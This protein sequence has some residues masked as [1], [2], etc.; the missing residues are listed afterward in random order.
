MNNKTKVYKDND[1]HQ[2]RTINQSFENHLDAIQNFKIDPYNPALLITSIQGS[3]KTTAI[4][5]TFAKSEDAILLVQ[6]NAK[7]DQMIELLKIYPNLNYRVFWGMERICSEYT[8]D[9]KDKEERKEVYSMVSNLRANKFRTETIHSI[10]HKK[11]NS[12]IGDCPYSTQNKELKGRIIETVARFNAQITEG[13]L[14][15]FIHEGRL[16][17]IDEADGLL[18]PVL[19]AIDNLPLDYDRENI[20]KNDVFL[21]EIWDLHTIKGTMDILTTQYKQMV[22]DINFSNYKNKDLKMIREISELIRLIS[23]KIYIKRLKK[24]DINPDFEKYYISEL[25]PIY[26]IFKYTIENKLK[27]ILGSATLRHHRINF[28]TVQNYFELALALQK[29]RCF[30]QL[31]SMQDH[32]VSYARQLKLVEYISNLIQIDGIKE[33]RADFI[34]RQREILIIP[35]SK[36]INKLHGY[37]ISHYLKAK[38]DQEKHDLWRYEIKEEIRFALNLYYVIFCHDP[39]NILLISFKAVNN[40]I[41]KEFKRIKEGGHLSRDPILK[42]IENTADFFS[43]EMHGT[44]ADTGGYDLILTIGDPLDGS[45]SQYAGKMNLI[46]TDKSG[47]IKNPKGFEIKPDADKKDKM[48]ILESMLSE[49]LEAFHRGRW[50][51]PIISIGNFLTSND[52]KEI[53]KNILSD[54]GFKIINGIEAWKQIADK[55]YR[56]KKYYTE[57]PKNIASLPDDL[58]FVD[59]SKW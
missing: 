24:W 57:I 55:N 8:K 26:F 34:P 39:K 46:N 54:D 20:V 45:V 58:K 52:D 19:L 49:L 13:N 47:K 23:Q 33:F 51:L 29:D 56:N 53:I 59:F 6:S 14:Y 3:G 12:D 38:T 11:F 5:E 28:E 7:I 37:S 43:N 27:L 42:R 1:V 21:P 31:K 15:K 9:F 35:S 16:I 48:F 30:K 4:I 32:G 2:A 36:K 44:N 40:I 22:E 50:N 17:L 25:P 41:N 18:S 10:L